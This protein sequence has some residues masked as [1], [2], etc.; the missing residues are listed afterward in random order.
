MNVSNSLQHRLLPV[1]LRYTVRGSRHAPALRQAARNAHHN[2]AAVFIQ[3][4]DEVRAVSGRQRFVN[5]KLTILDMAYINDSGRPVTGGDIPRNGRS[6]LIRIIGHI[7]IILARHLEIKTVQIRPLFGP[8]PFFR[9]HACIGV[10][11]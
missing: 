1:G 2:I 11:V 5:Y 9:R 10:Y 7:N 3:P 8:R 6:A 4:F